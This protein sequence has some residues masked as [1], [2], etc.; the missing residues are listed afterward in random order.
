MGNSASAEQSNAVGFR[1]LG[2]QRESPA[3]AAELVSFFDFIVGAQGRLFK[4]LDNTFIELIKESE[5]KPLQVTVYNCKSGETRE[6]DIV[7]SRSWGGQGMLGVTIR[8][9]SYFNAEENLVRVLEVARHSPAQLAGL[10][11]GVDYLLGTAEKV[12]KNPDVLFEEVTRNI[13]CPMEIYVYNTET[14]SVRTAIILPT[15]N[16]DGDGCLGASVGHGYLHRLPA[17]C[18]ETSGRSQEI[19]AASAP[20]MQSTSPLNGQAKEDGDEV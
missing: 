20:V 12:F 18:L 2:V 11:G 6:V 8:F 4:E 17:K 15:Y 9:D 13:D 3:S 10:K 5:G 14:D 19:G 16:W 7:P 1:V